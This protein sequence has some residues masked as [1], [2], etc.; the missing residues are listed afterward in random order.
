VLAGE[1]KAAVC[2][3]EQLLLLVVD[4]RGVAPTWLRNTISEYSLERVRKNRDR[5]KAEAPLCGH[6]PTVALPLGGED[7]RLLEPGD[8]HDFA[9][10]AV[11]LVGATTR[12]VL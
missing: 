12:S 11:I 8:G 2:E 9:G 6:L 4:K 10:F 7:N 5:R 3:A 1:G